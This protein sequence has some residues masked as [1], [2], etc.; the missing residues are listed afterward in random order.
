M[1]FHV[2]CKNGNTVELMACTDTMCR[3][4][5]ITL[6]DEE[7]AQ[8]GGDDKV[9]AFVEQKMTEAYKAKGDEVLKYATLAEVLSAL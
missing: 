8:N 4:L 3:Q 7:I 6:T 5:K 2:G 9:A 1:E